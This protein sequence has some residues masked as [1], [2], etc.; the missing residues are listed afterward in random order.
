[1]DSK[2]CYSLY[3]ENTPYMIDNESQKAYTINA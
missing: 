1:M 3:Q 2:S